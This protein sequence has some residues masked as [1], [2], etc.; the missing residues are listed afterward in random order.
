M[1]FLGKEVTHLSNEKAALETANKGL[2][3]DNKSMSQ[4][5]SAARRE[6][7][8]LEIGRENLLKAGLEKDRQVEE[9]SLALAKALGGLEEHKALLKGQTDRVAELERVASE[10]TSRPYEEIIAEYKE[11]PEYAEEIR[12][13][14]QSIAEQIVMSSQ[15]REKSE[16]KFRAGFEAMQEV[17]A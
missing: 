4:D 14:Q 9:K 10:S 2:V 11:S 1:E 5:L 3:S 6:V 13:L 8:K 15:Y 12:A 7:T 17:C 16:Q